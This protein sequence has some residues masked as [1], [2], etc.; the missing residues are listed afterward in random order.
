VEGTLQGDIS[1]SGDAEIAPGG[2]VEGNVSARSL[3]V[4]GSLLGDV[5]VEG[6]VTIRSGATVRGEL[7]GT[8]VSIE[9]GSRVS[10]KLDTELQLSLGPAPRRR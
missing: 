9:P 7:R 2:S 5:V 10:I 4:S 8:E 3:Q 6:P 1:V